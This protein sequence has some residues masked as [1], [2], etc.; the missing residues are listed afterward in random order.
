MKLR[1]AYNTNGLQSHRFEDACAMM[2]ESGYQGVALTLDHMHLDPLYADSAA[3]NR[4][5]QVLRQYKLDVV[6]D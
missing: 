2:A 1:Y 5:K 4:V 3:I 6:I